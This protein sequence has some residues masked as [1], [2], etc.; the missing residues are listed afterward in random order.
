MSDF[1]NIN[2][3]KYADD[4]AVNIYSETKCLPKEEMYGVT[5][6]LRRAAASTSVA[7]GLLPPCGVAANSDAG[8]PRSDL[9]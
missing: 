5:P 7:N 9:W 4:L 6:Q 2:A 1:K 8:F 3:W